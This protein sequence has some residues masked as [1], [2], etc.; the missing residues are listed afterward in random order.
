VRMLSESV[1][2]LSRIR[3]SHPGRL[4]LPALPDTG[5]R[6]GRSVVLYNTAADEVAPATSQFFSMSNVASAKTL[7]VWRCVLCVAAPFPLATGGYLAMVTEITGA[8]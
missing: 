6:I 2:G 4:H 5:Y 1:T 7:A 3:R 8:D